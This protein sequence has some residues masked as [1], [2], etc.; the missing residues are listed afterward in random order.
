MSE[1]K[2]IES[3]IR[4]VWLREE[5]KPV[6]ILTG[7]PPEYIKAD[8]VGISHSVLKLPQRFEEVESYIVNF[9]RGN[10]ELLEALQFDTL[11]IAVNQAKAIAGI[12]SSEWRE[13]NISVPDDGRVT[14]AMGR[15]E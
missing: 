11:D 9:Y 7:N 10:G 3:L 12:E 14:W 13:C 8:W 1:K 15:K 2:I 4:C 5:L 6:P